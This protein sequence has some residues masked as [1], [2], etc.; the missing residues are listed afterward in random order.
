MERTDKILTQE[1]YLK[2]KAKITELEFDQMFS[3]KNHSKKIQKLKAK[4][5][6]V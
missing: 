6:E 3:G 1:E 4:I 5:G 2:I